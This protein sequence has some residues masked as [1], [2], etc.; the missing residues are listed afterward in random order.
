M[1]E[2]DALEQAIADWEALRDC[3]GLS[4]QPIRLLITS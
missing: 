3:T 1:V 2:G 4:P